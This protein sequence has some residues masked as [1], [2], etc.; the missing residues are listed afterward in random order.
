[1]DVTQIILI[2]FIVL[3]L[4]AYPIM[5]FSK[6]KKETQ[7]MQEQT[8]SLKRGDK[9][10][11]TSGVYGT[12]VDLQLEG[13]KKIITIETGT[14]K[15]KGYISID[16]YAIFQIIKDEPVQEPTSED[17]TASI[18]EQINPTKKSK[19][20]SKKNKDEVADSSV[21]LTE[22]VSEKKETESNIDNADNK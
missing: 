3:L 18:E 21:V 4:I 6:N 1:M 7:R 2:V 22:N 16:A 20:L 14:D 5:V 17:A 15:K 10:L 19:F 12:I 8:N 11:T 9:V 13:D